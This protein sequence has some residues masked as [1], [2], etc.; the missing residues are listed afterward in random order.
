LHSI[1][2][3]GWKYL[4][5]LDEAWF[6]LLN[7]HE[8]IWLRDHEDPTTIER[9]MISSSKTMLTVVWNPHGIQ[10]VNVLPKGQKWTS[11]YY[12]D[13]ILPEIGALRDA[14]DR[15]KWWYTLTMP[16]YTSERE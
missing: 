14:R 15:Q 10:L 9:Q 4:I 11:Q 7:Q 6:Y 1:Q 12:I 13:H 3:Q 16:S 2:H 5:P 8:Q